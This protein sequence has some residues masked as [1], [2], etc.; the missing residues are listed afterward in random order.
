V[1]GAPLAEH[2]SSQ[3]TS[4]EL[5]RCGGLRPNVARRANAVTSARYGVCVHRYAHL[6]GGRVHE[7][8]AVAL[9]AAGARPTRGQ[10]HQHRGSEASSADR[11]CKHLQEPD[12][13]RAITRHQVFVL[14]FVTLP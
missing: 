12:L 14:P 6:R 8:G 1:F 9:G 5:P 13:R 11:S 2:E 4:S 7:H 3:K 10:A